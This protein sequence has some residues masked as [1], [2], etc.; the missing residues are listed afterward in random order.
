[1]EVLLFQS[2][3]YHAGA[4]AAAVRVAALHRAFGRFASE[5]EEVCS[6][7][8]R[9][10][11][12]GVGNVDSLVSRQLAVVLLLVLRCVSGEEA[13][14][15]DG[16]G[17]ARLDRA[18]RFIGVCGGGGVSPPARVGEG[19]VDGKGFAVAPPSVFD[20]VRDVGLARRVQ[21]AGQAHPRDISQ[22]KSLDMA[23]IIILFLITCLLAC[24][25]ILYAAPA[26]ARI[27]ICYSGEIISR[28][29]TTLKNFAALLR[30]RPSANITEQILCLARS[31]RRAQLDMVGH[32]MVAAV[33]FDTRVAC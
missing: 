16:P 21:E 11:E 23:F 4:S 17:L 1:M 26:L 9:D 14:F 31:S 12:G 3:T 15:E 20:D 28:G 32:S 2:L 18:Y 24:F 8:A 30:P 22:L 25:T 5:L 29:D 13:L 33:I 10:F 27:I 19:D 6:H 7:R